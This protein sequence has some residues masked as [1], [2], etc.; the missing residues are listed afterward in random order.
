MDLPDVYFGAV[1]PLPDWRKVNV[2]DMDVDD[3]EVLTETP[4]SVVDLLGFD[5]LELE[6]TQ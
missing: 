2:P 5:P 4:K 1:G 3:D 6:V